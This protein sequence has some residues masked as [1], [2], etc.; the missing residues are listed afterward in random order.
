MTQ[1][2]TTRKKASTKRATAKKTTHKKRATQQAESRVLDLEIEAKNR[3]DAAKKLE[4][5][6]KEAFDQ[7]QIA[8]GK[9]EPESDIEKM[10]NLEDLL[11]VKQTNPF[12]TTS[13]A[14][15]EEKMG[16]MGLSDLQAMAVKIGILP[17][18]N[19]LSLKNKIKR[20]FKSHPGAGSAYHIGFQ[21]PLVDPNGPEADEILR[22]LNTM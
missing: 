10:K 3:E 22:I 8:D 6:A 7:L 11:G 9:K 5:E 13:V 1:K 20:Q 14:V 18:G 19:K 16:A 4:Q 12:G 21:K 2:K 15:L 17:S